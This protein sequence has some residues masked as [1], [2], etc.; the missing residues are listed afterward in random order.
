[1]SANQE[2]ASL[3][4][5][6]GGAGDMEEEK[7]KANDLSDSDSEPDPEK[8]RVS[9]TGNVV[10]YTV[11]PQTD[12]RNDQGVGNPD[13]SDV[14]LDPGNAVTAGESTPG[15]ENEGALTVSNQKDGPTT[16]QVQGTDVPETQVKQ[17][18]KAVRVDQI[19]A[20]QE[21][22]EQNQQQQSGGAD[23]SGG[24]GSGGSG[25]DSPGGARP[26]PPGSSG[27]GF[28]SG[29]LGWPGGGGDGGL[30]DQLTSPLGL[31]LVVVAGV[32]VFAASNDENDDDNSGGSNSGE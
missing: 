10:G 21:Q 32:A 11:D 16:V 8:A 13:L 18:G 9:S 7:Q 1:M 26:E 12:I 24:G 22:V 23:T 25:G 14:S 30:V 27:M 28:G 19:D 2:F 29:G 17:G 4:G 31:V 5:G 3:T 15:G 20:V 6:S